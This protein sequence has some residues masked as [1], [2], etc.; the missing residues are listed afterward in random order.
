MIQYKEEGGS[1]VNAICMHLLN[2]KLTDI[3][4]KKFCA[5]YE[6][7][8]TIVPNFRKISLSHI[9]Q[10]NRTYK[11]THI[12]ITHAHT[13]NRARTHTHTHTHTH[14]NNRKTVPVCEGINLVYHTKSSDWPMKLL[15]ASLVNFHTKQ[16]QLYCYS[17]TTC[18]TIPCLTFIMF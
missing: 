12:Y 1:T 14:T 15:S 10:P 13:H 9:L 4:K 2:I 16:L 18:C 5:I 6:K 8:I 3:F 11:H 7:F 17:N